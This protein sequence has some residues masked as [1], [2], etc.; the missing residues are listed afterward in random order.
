MFSVFVVTL[1]FYSHHRAHE[2]EIKSFVTERV[3]NSM[4]QTLSGP[5]ED[6]RDSSSKEAVEW[7]VVNLLLKD[8]NAENSNIFIVNVGNSRK[9]APT[10]RFAEGI[11]HS[12]TLRLADTE[13]EANIITILPN[14]RQPYVV[15]AVLTL[16][17]GLF[18]LFRF[19]SYQPLDQFSLAKIYGAIF[20]RKVSSKKSWGSWQLTHLGTGSGMV[21]IKPNGFEQAN[22]DGAVDKCIDGI[23]TAID[24]VDE[25]F[26]KDIKNLADEV[27]QSNQDELVK[28]VESI[29]ERMKLRPVLDSDEDVREFADYVRN[30]AMN[31]AVINLKNT[32][33]YTK[34]LGVESSD[35]KYE[36]PS[37]W[38]TDGYQ[39]FMPKTFWENMLRSLNSGLRMAYNKPISG[40]KIDT[41][42][43]LPFIVIDFFIEGVNIDEDNLRKLKGYIKSGG[44]GDLNDLVQAIANYGRLLLLDQKTI[45]DLTD[46]KLGRGALAR[47]LTMRFMLRRIDKGE[48]EQVITQ[49]EK[50]LAT[51]V[52]QKANHG[53]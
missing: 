5:W 13:V 47:T 18:F 48:K 12:L 24:I 14:N 15:S 38:L 41:D 9:Q 39:V 46:R 36:T 16:M 28:I 40:I 52:N 17:I 23:E 51:R 26:E 7:G 25:A 21:T 31:E 33:L 8:Y 50:V 42:Q 2:L 3:K 44:V 22:D 45:I 32:D 34:I 49:M 30:V 6:A 4:E 53:A 11:S 35:I 1:S 27:W 10:E 29:R 43:E 37:P 20:D 19:P